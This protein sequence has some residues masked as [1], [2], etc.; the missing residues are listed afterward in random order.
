LPRNGWEVISIPKKVKNRVKN[1]AE[2]LGA[3]EWL[4]V[5]VSL[6]LAD[7]DEVKKELEKRL[8]LLEKTVK[9]FVWGNGK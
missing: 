4:V 5:D 2:S 9:E 1:K 3:P 8:K 7:K 6:N